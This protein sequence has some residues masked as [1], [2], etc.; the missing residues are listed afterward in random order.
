MFWTIISSEEC[1][2]IDDE[3]HVVRKIFSAQRT[4]LPKRIYYKA[5]FVSYKLI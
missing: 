1:I 3:E 4:R 5:S 2:G